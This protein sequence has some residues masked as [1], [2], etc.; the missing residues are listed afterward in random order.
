MS[1]HVQLLLCS[2]AI[3]TRR[4]MYSDLLSAQSAFV[5]GWDSMVTSEGAGADVVDVFLSD[6]RNKR[7]V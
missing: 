3:S 4:A 1:L 5:E 7:L 2:K 6:L